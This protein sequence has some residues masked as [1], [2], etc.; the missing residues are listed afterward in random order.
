MPIV[1]SS[2]QPT[3]VSPM[4]AAGIWQFIPSTGKDFNLLQD[5]NYDARFDIPSSTQAAIRFLA[6][7]KNH[8]KGDWLLALAAYNCGQ[9]RVDNAISDNLAKGLDVDF[10]SLALPEETRQY[11]PRLLALSTIFAQHSVYNLKLPM[12]K[13][14]PYFITVKLTE[15]K[16]IKQVAEKPLSAIAQL[17]NIDK[18]QFI[19]LNPGY[20]SELLGTEGPF[21]FHM[22]IASANHLHRQLSI[23][24]QQAISA[25][26]PLHTFA[27]VDPSQ[28]GSELGW[29]P[30]DWLS[31][32]RDNNAEL[33]LLSPDKPLSVKNKSD[34]EG[35]GF[36]T[37]H[38]VDSNETL[39]SIAENFNVSEDVIRKL[40]KLKRRQ[41]V[42]LGQALTIPVK[43][44]PSIL[45]D[46]QDRVA[47]L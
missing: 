11:V 15:E 2:Y 19:S 47:W 41:N 30:T 5:G 24:E 13:N 25:T 40:N 18:E 32:N 23:L 8:F 38:Y 7:L 28:T 29:F 26:K 9:T 34:D 43:K 17:A 37:L 44:N 45:F 35:N 14:E 21:T 22:P 12:V 16:D 4:S 39:K 27:K 6:G 10:W 36:V 3:A 1:E 33:Q 31:I 46:V 42:A 20:Q